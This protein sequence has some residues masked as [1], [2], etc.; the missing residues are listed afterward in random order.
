MK[1][2]QLTQDLAM[3]ARNAIDYI[4]EL[5]RENDGLRQVCREIYEVWGGSD[6]LPIPET[7]PEA[8]LLKLVEQMR[9]AA[10]EGLK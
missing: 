8:Y 9:D 4:R 3:I 6:A 10:R 1:P 2:D 5:E 7:A